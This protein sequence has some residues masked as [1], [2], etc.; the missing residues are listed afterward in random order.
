MAECVFRTSI[1]RDPHHPR[2]AVRIVLLARKGQPSVL[3]ASTSARLPMRFVAVASL[4]DVLEPFKSILDASMAALKPAEVSP[5]AFNSQ[6]LPRHSSSAPAILTSTKVSHVLDA[7]EGRGRESPV[8]DAH[9]RHPTRSRGSFT[10]LTCY[11]IRRTRDTL[12]S[13]AHMIMVR[14]CT[15]FLKLRPSPQRMDLRL[16]KPCSVGSLLMKSCPMKKVDFL[17]SCSMLHVWQYR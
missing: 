4:R 8:Y 2:S 12:Y 5:D 7:P 16:G 14:F 17:A 13:L 11:P 10:V 15:V 3:R 1:L 6:S 9:G